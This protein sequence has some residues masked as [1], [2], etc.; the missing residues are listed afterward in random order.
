MRHALV[1]GGSMVGMCAARVLAEHVDRVTIVDRD[2]Y[3]ATAD[4]RV[5]VPQSHH[6]HALLARGQMELERMFPGF[7]AQLRA[8][9]AHVFDFSQHFAIL[10]K[11]GWA[12]RVPSGLETVWAS[13][14]LIESIVRA[15]L[16]RLANVELRERTTVQAL[17]FDKR[18]RARVVGV[19]VKAKDE[20]ITL[21]LDADL[22]VDASGR[23]T[24]IPRWLDEAGIAPPRE[25]VVEAFAGYASRFYKRP[26]PE[27]RPAEWWWD[28]LWIEGVP[29]DFPRGGV[30]FPVE[31]DRWLVTA[32][33]FSKDYPPTNEKG[34]LAFLKSL[35][36]PA[37]ADVVER[38]EPLSDI[39][40]NRS[41]TN[42]FRHY[43]GWGAKVDG[44][45]ALGDS[46]CAFNPVYGQGMSTGAVC[47]SIL[48][49]ELAR[50]AGLTRDLPARHHAAQEKFLKGVWGLAA[51]ADFLWTLTE[52]DRPAGATLVQPYLDLML[53][54]LHADPSVLRAVIPVFHLVEEP[55]RVVAPATMAAVLSSAL[56]RRVKARTFRAAT[57]PR[58]SRPPAA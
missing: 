38:C 50:G 8:A 43:G 52:G 55:S 32:V 42:R 19:T 54:G 44:L 25:D 10:R 49:T 34:F 3:P 18:E 39:V 16:R 4:H 20:G 58:G 31:G 12:P 47:A 53:E 26:T 36:S 22:V 13:R 40:Q 6:A 30:G 35:A 48:R 7:E 57:L 37:L 29:P 51:G 45:L 17:R 11:W 23:G 28:G 27:T 21:D 14:P 2:S 56:R 1:I 24:K 5:G 9:G 41:T 15:E 33:G 46:V